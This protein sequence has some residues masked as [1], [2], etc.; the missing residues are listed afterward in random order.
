MHDELLLEVPESE[1]EH[2]RE[3]VRSEMEI[4]LHARSASDRRHRRRAKLDGS[5][6]LSFISFML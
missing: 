5:K 4:R 2:T 1:V 3:I 6:A